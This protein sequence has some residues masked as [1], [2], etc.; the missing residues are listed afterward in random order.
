MPYLSI[1]GVPAC[2][3]KKLLTDILRGE[4][5]FTGYIAADAGELRRT[6][7]MHHYYNNTLDAAVGCLSAGCN[8][9]VEGSNQ[10]I[11]Y[12]LSKYKVTH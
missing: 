2:A 7:T 9:E 3:N 8:L 4:W 5:N 6:I 11:Y 1:N 12:S 10:R